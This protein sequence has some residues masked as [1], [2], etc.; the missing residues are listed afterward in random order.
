MAVI[1]HG[2]TPIH[3]P[4]GVARG[5]RLDALAVL[6]PLLVGV[7]VVMQLVVVVTVMVIVVV[8]VDRADDDGVGNVVVDASVF[9]LWEFWLRDA[10][11]GGDD[12]EGL[13]FDK[14]GVRVSALVVGSVV[15]EDG[16]ED[17]RVV[18]DDADASPKF[19]ARLLNLESGKLK[20]LLVSL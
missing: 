2:V 8:V 3:G 9:V 7:D 17:V 5:R 1:D 16:V 20:D 11:V 12:E 4:V 19:V 10:R 13:N 14:A 6:I 18:V 15:V